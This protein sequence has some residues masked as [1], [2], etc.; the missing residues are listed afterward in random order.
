MEAFVVW[1]IFPLCTVRFK[2]FSV[3]DIFALLVLFNILNLDIL[4]VYELTGNDI[5][6]LCQPTLI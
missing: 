1:Y 6:L 2:T 4:M 3:Y 5:F